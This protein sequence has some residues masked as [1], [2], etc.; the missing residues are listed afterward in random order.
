MKYNIIKNQQELFE[1]AAE[2]LAKEMKAL[3]KKKTSIVLAIPGGR[4]MPPLFAEL[5]KKDIPWKNIHFFIVDERLVPLDHPESNFKL[6]LDNLFTELLKDKKIAKDNIH[7]FKYNPN[8]SDRGTASYQKELALFG[9]K[10]DIIILSAGEDGHVAGLFPN[11]SIKVNASFFITMNNAPK[12]PP[13]RMSSSR[14]LLLKSHVAILLITGEQKRQALQNLKNPKVSVEE[15]PA[16]IIQSIK[17]AYV[18]TD[19]S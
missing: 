17:D 7:P 13:E 5:K 18:F 11:R 1:A 2:T 14:N 9:G 3:L 16:K 12:P 15:C 6:A 19:L 10:F 8:K 4:S